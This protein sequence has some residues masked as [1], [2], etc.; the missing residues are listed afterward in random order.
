MTSTIAGF[1]ALTVGTSSW[2]D[3]MGRGAHPAEVVAE[4]F[5]GR[6]APWATV[7]D[8]SNNYGAG[9][10]ETLIGDAVRR[11]G[12]VPRGVLIATKLDRDMATGDFSGDRMRASLDESLRRLGVSSVPLLYLHDPE[13]LTYAEAFAPGGA[14]EAL[15]AMKREGLAA[16][17]GI[18][19]GP[20]RMLQR[21][22]ETGLFDAVITHNRYTLV[23]RSAREL[24]E[25]A[26]T[27][28]V[29]VSNAAPYGSAPLAKW[30]E[31]VTSYAYRPAHPDVVRAIA[32]M[33]EVTAGYGVPLAAAALQ[34]SLRDPLVATTVVGVNSADQL[35][36]TLDLA[37][38]EIPDE[39]WGHLEGLV[40]GPH[41]RQD[42]PGPSPWDHF[43]NHLL[44]S[45]NR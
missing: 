13:S 21:Y 33:G 45:L 14:V 23:D 30:P 35:A 12:G 34:F 42:P 9:V 8:T 27:R 3:A 5:S 37:Q 20:A 28:G 15:V 29:A 24:L 16:R 19:G 31:P 10:S 4:V 18:S 40:P 17:I 25:A 36:R 1:S 43:D 44:E 6:T 7:I 26:A 32:A 2:A 22:V 39:V 38:F 41:A 11:G